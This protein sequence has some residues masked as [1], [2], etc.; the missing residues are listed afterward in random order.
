MS[1]WAAHRHS[2]GKGVRIAIV[3]SDVD[4]QHEDLRGRLDRVKSYAVDEASAE[5]SHGTAI[6]SVIGANAN[7]AK[8]IVGVA[9]GAG[10][11]TCTLPAGRRLPKVAASAIATLWRKRW[12][13]CLGDLRI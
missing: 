3:D 13:R 7:N 4:R 1:V 11:S 6:A 2:V 10:L 12:I 8:G 9:P 5:T